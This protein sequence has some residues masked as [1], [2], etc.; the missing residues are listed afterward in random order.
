M[1]QRP[2]RELKFIQSNRVLKEIVVAFVQIVMF[3][4][5]SSLVQI[6]FPPKHWGVNEG[7]GLFILYVVFALVAFINTIVME[8]I[9]RRWIP[10]VF[11][12]VFVVTFIL[13]N[14]SMINH[15][16]YRTMAI[17]IIAVASFTIPFEIKRKK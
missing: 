11:A 7:L 13:V 2:T 15:Y 6:F 16:P 14:Y 10:W 8:I 3:V 17:M 1:I 5:F 12:L 4:G 9:C